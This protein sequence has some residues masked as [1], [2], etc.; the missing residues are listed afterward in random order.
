MKPIVLYLRVSTL[1][2]DVTSQSDDLKKWALLKGFNVVKIFG[3]TVS[4]Y[5]VNAQRIQYDLM[6]TYVLNN[7]VKDIAVWEISRL[8][9]SLRKTLEELDFFTQNKINVHFRKEGIESI[10]NNVTNQLLLTILSSMAQ[11][12]RDTFIER[13]NRGRMSAVMKGRMIGYSKPPYGYTSDENGIICIEETEANAVKLMYDLIIKGNTLYSI[14]QELNSRNIPTRDTIQGKKKIFKG[15]EIDFLW[16]PNTVRRIIGRTLNKGIRVFK[17]TTITV[18]AIVSEE[19]WEKANKTFEENLG[20][21]NRTKYEYLFKG[22][23]KCGKCGRHI[24]THKAK[25]VDYGYYLCNAIVNKYEKCKNV[26]YINSGLI[27]NN[28]YP[29]LFDHKYINQIMKK[30]APSEI[31]KKEKENQIT[32][33]LSQIKE[34]ENK[35]TRFK[36]L[37]T[38]GHI[39]FNEY[40]KEISSLKNEIIDLTN[41]IGVIQSEINILSK[42]DINQILKTYKSAKDFNIK[43]DFILKYVNDIRLYQIQIA[44]VK[45]Q[46]P[47]YKNEKIVYVEIF[48][49]GFSIPIKMIVTPNTRNV[50]ISQ[51]LNYLPEYSMVV[52]ISQKTVI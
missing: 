23:M 14:A 32:Y 20:Y 7:N 21:H 36:K 52:D 33:Y 25:D 37:Y 46:T 22:K 41:K 11:M 24:V 6:K 42:I 9:R 27:D 39:D 49:F 47:L 34:V 4:G 51:N 15:K 45:W 12:E 13:G 44:N 43:R 29:A 38:T 18:P 10:S 19:I 28:L 40:E 3:E 8:S 17:G 50:I 35:Q 31:E 26:K 30:E 5:D 2:Q 16:S 48:A 1:D